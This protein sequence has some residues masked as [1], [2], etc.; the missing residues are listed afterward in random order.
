MTDVAE[1]YA[2]LLNPIRDLAANWN[3]D[4]A[5]ELTEVCLMLKMF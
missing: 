2:H 1:R 4:V 5:N 3:I